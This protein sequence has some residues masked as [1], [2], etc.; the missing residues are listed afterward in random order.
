MPAGSVG[1]ATLAAIAWPNLGEH[2]RHCCADL[3]C[4]GALLLLEVT[5]TAAT[6]GGTNEPRD[7]HAAR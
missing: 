4:R 7:A 3:E 1:T 6:N 5:P 2:G